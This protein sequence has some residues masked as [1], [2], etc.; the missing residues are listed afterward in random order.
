MKKL[1]LRLCLGLG[2]VW[3]GAALAQSA[4]PP[5]DAPAA[6]ETAAPTTALPQPNRRPPSPLLPLRRRSRSTRAM[7]PG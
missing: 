6:A 2:L 4:E 1:L 3:A 7:W 5:K